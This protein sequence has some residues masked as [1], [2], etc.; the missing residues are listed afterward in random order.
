M[1]KCDVSKCHAACC[2]IVPIPRETF[3]KHVGDVQGPYNVINAID[4]QVV[5]MAA[6]KPVCAFLTP[7]FRC[8]IYEDRP[9]I[10]RRFGNGDHPLLKCRFL[11]K[12]T[13]ADRKRIADAAERVG[14]SGLKE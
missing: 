5:V 12:L 8:A 13:A 3:E 7:E 9:E 6:G 2:G 4:G 10:C 14:L 11:C 1:K